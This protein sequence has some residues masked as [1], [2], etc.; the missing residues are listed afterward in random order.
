M[1]GGRQGRQLRAVRRRR[2][3]SAEPAPSLNDVPPNPDAKPL[4]PKDAA[5]KVAGSVFQP[6]GVGCRTI[7]AFKLDFTNLNDLGKL[8]GLDV[9]KFTGA[10]PTVAGFD[11]QKGGRVFTTVPFKLPKA[12]DQEVDDGGD[13][14]EGPDLHR[15]RHRGLRG[16]GLQALQRGL[17]AE[18]VDPVRVGPLAR[19][20]ERRLRPDQRP[21]RRRLPAAAARQQ[22]AGREPRR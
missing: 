17:P 1:F 16:R 8:A 18:Q 22:S 9:G 6:L 12:L 4:Q 5:G 2:R 3:R 13:Q 11:D 10:I 15:H 21:V 7:P 14:E 19:P 20:A